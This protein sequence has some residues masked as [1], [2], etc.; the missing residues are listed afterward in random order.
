MPPKPRRATSGDAPALAALHAACFDHAWPESDFRDHIARDLVLVDARLQSLIVLREGGG[1]AEILTLAT[2]PDT[3]GQGLGAA[4]VRAALERTEAAAVFLEV[5]E[6]NA[7]ALA[8]YRAQG[9]RAFGRRPAYYRRA[10]GRVA[11]ITMEWKRDSTS[12]PFAC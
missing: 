4:L 6:D 2:H 5:A 3:R 7:P 8:L 1:Q 11:A 10:S 12:E 9:F